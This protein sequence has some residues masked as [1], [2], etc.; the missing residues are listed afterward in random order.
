VGRRVIRKEGM[1]LRR[2]EDKMEKGGV[3]VIIRQKLIFI[4]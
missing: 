3:R 2:G 4:I 1:K